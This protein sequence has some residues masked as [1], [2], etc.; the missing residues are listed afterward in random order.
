MPRTNAFHHR[1]L[2]INCTKTQLPKVLSSL[3]KLGVE[4][5][6]ELILEYAGTRQ[7]VR[8]PEQR[9]RHSKTMKLHWEKRKNTQDKIR[10]SAITLVKN[11]RNKKYAI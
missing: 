4:V 1:Q 11:I 6:L 2:V 10:K 5:P 3:S 8:T 9:E 7:Y